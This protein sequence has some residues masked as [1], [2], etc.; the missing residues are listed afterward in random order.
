MYKEFYLDLEFS[1][2]C[3]DELREM[4]KEKRVY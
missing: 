3:D 4:N 2:H 1:D